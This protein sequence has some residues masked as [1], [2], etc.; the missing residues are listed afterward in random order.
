MF[1]EEEIKNILGYVWITGMILMMLYKG[2]QKHGWDGWTYTDSEAEDYVFIAG[3]PAVVLWWIFV[4]LPFRL[5]MGA[6]W[7]L[8]EI[9]ER[10]TKA[11]EKELEDDT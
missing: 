4:I 9:V 2:I 10:V 11:F 1:S 8:A 7:L 5:F 6:G 3:W